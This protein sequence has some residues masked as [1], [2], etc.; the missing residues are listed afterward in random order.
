[1]YED[2]RGFVSSAPRL[3]CSTVLHR[4]KGGGP[5]HFLEGGFQKVCRPHP[6][7]LWS[8]ISM[9]QIE[10]TNPTQMGWVPCK[11]CMAPP[12]LSWYTEDIES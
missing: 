5:I 10:N 4:N 12:P 9:E 7:C 2:T 1:M 8:T 11:K 3:W 6:L